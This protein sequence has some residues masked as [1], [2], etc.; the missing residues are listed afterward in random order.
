MSITYLNPGIRYATPDLEVI[1]TSRI[2]LERKLSLGE[3]L[4]L[5]TLATKISTLKSQLYVIDNRVRELLASAPVSLQTQALGE[6]LEDMRRAASLTSTPSAESNAGHY[7]NE[8]KV[9]INYSL[10]SIGSQA[11]AL[12]KLLDD[13]SEWAMEDVTHFISEQESRR[14]GLQQTVERLT[15][16]RIELQA[17]KQRINDAMRVYEDLTVMDRW[18]PILKDLLK[19][20]PGSANLMVLQAGVVGVKNI[21]QIAAEAVR[22]DDLVAAQA[23]AH[24]MLTEQQTQ[25]TEYRD[26]LRVLDAR[27]GQ[28]RNVEGIEG[29]KQRY[30]QELRKLADALNLFLA[31]RQRSQDP[32]EEFARAF[33]TQANTLSTWLVD[34][35]KKWK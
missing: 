8:V 7:R 26:Q 13:L 18:I 5:E 22:Y 25:L 11:G 33:I 20:K 23:R 32:V 34:L 17:D 10:N 1:R 35:G 14:G 6:L 29:L 28:L 16:R 19:V 31:L 15:T 3:T 27:T 21:L 9:V 30:E 4:Y 24:D 2:A 12:I